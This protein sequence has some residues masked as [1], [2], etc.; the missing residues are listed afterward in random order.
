VN[1]DQIE[2]SYGGYFGGYKTLRYS[3]GTVSWSISIKP[4]E[5][6]TKEVPEER[7]EVFWQQ[8]ETI[9]VWDWQ[10]R[11]VQNPRGQPPR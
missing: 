8:L 7:L 4:Y 1:N 2:F 9:G 11:Y 10:D 6:H 3:N 5:E